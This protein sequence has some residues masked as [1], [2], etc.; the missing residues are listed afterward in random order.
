MKIFATLII[1]FLLSFPSFAQAANEQAA[2]KQTTSENA[3]KAKIEKQIETRA[4]KVGYAIRCV[5]C[6][7]QPIEESNATLAQDMRKLVRARMRKGDSD[8]QVIAYMQ[9]RYGDFVLL[10]PP[11]QA[12]TF[13]LWFGPAVMLVMF[14]LW[15][16]Q[17][18]RGASVIIEAEPLS[19]TEREKFE[20]LA[21]K[22]EG[23][24]QTSNPQGDDT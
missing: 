21:A 11:V 1:T 19:D 22:Q 13:L 14:L 2:N 23:N 7:N 10:K 3:D 20:K 24:Q 12:N 6:Q 8:E 16:V 18:V 15:Y 9:E 4:R 17:R 5:V